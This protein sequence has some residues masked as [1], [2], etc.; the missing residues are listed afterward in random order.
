[1]VLVYKFAF[2]FEKK[3]DAPDAGQA[4]QRKDDAGKQAVHPAEQETNQVKTEQ[5]N[6]APVEGTNDGQDKCQ[7]I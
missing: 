5:T 4:Y 7:T 1:M 2:V 3:G 6:A